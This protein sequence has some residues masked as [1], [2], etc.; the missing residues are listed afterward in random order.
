[1][2][3]RARPG[4]PNT[5]VYRSGGCVPGCVPARRVVRPQAGSIWLGALLV[6]AV[7][8]FAVLAQVRGLALNPTAMWQEYQY[9]QQ[10]GMLTW[11]NPIM[12]MGRQIQVLIIV[13]NDVPSSSPH[14]YGASWFAALV[15]VVPFLQGYAMEQGWVRWGPAEWL[16]RTY[17]GENAAGTGFLISAEGYLNFG[18]AGAF[19]EVMVFGMFI[20]WLAKCFARHPSGPKAFLFLGALGPAALLIRN[21]ANTATSTLAQLLVVSL[22]LHWALGAQQIDSAESADDEQIPLPARP[23]WDHAEPRWATGNRWGCL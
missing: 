2:G 15:H 18:Y 5:S 10:S 6:A 20:R 23:S 3:N 14:W 22:V 4:R 8:V 13:S 9:K 17:F 7:S 16:T 21:H 1:M 19:L 11:L 12:E